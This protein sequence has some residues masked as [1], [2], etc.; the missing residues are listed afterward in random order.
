MRDYGKPI[1][2]R[3]D[4]RA[5]ERFRQLTAPFILRRVKTD[6]SVIADLPEKNEIDYFTSLTPQQVKLYEECLKT[7]LTDVE[8][9]DKE[10]QQASDATMKAVVQNLRMKR[11]GSILRMITH[12]KQIADSPSILSRETGDEPDSGKGEALLSLIAPSLEAGGKVLVF[13]QYAE[14]GERLARWIEK[15]RGRKP[16]FLHGGTTLAERQAMTDRFQNDPQANILILTL[17]A[18]GTGL[19]LTAA[20]V[21]VHYD[22]WWN[23]AV[24]SQATDRAYRIGQTKNVLVYRFITAGTFEE[25]ID[26]LLAN[27]KRLAD[28]TVAGGEKWIGDMTDKELEALFR[29]A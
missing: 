14:M 29:L 2:E 12:L 19:N 27:K 21:V 18:G 28:L 25:R 23:P 13:T 6:K 5:L 15:A 20:S 9:L 8:T 11:R 10:A 4:R 16:D 7:G 1:E 22:L 24:E 3:M 17:K 26:K